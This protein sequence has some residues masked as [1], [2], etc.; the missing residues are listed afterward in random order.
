[1]NQPYRSD[2]YY[3]QFFEVLTVCRFYVLSHSGRQCTSCG[4]LF[5][6]FCL[7]FMLAISCR[8]LLL[9]ASPCVAIV[10]ASQWWKKCSGPLTVSC[11][12]NT[13]VTVCIVVI[14]RG[15]SFVIGYCG[16]TAVN[17][18]VFCSWFLYD[19]AVVY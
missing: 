7:S 5:Q 12:S 8:W 10:I 14:N 13:K 4:S 2:R 15:R 16:K 11:F 18:N 9:L 19:T 3:A 17:K 6:S 1:M